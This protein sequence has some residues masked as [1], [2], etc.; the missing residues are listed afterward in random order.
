MTDSGR[1]ES[2]RLSHLLED[3]KNLIKDR[4]SIIATKTQKTKSI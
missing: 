4:Q 1:V 2:P 3:N